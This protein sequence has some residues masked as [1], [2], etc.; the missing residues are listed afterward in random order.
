MNLSEYI[1]NV[2]YQLNMSQQQL[3]KALNVNFSTI[4]RWENNRAMPS[5]LAQKTLLDFCQNNFIEI[6]DELKA[7]LLSDS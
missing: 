4:N 2:R 6:P 1:R 5:N 3:A 7:T